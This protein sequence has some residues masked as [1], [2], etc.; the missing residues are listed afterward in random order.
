[1]TYY[2]QQVYKLRDLHYPLQH[3][4]DRV[5]QAKNFMDSASTETMALDDIAA[6]AFLSKFHFIRLF[7]RCYGRT[8]HQYLTTTKMAKAKLLLQS[9]M[10]VST[11]CFSLGYTSTTT[12]SGLFKKMTGYT[13]VQYQQKKQY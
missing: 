3:Q 5:I 2:Q 6:S 9:G 1:M 12:F 8:P 10:T 11:T 7:K 13:P 4:L